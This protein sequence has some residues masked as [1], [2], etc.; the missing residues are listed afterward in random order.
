MI[1]E[2]I[3]CPEKDWLSVQLSL[4]ARKIK[5]QLDWSALESF[6]ELKNFLLPPRKGEKNWKFTKFN[7]KKT[8]TFKTVLNLTNDRKKSNI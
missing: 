8:R 7:F 5:M 4:A 3:W 6:R 1:G 2:S